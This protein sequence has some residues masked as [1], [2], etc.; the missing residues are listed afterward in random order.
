MLSNGVSSQLKRIARGSDGVDIRLYRLIV[1]VTVFGVGHHIDHVIRGNHVGWP[2]IPE[3]TAF[4]YSLGF[5]PLIALGL[6]LSLAD[7]VGAGYWAVVTGAGFVMV[8]VL[9][10]GPLAVEPPGDVVGPYESATVGYVA[11]A[12]LV[13]FV[14]TLA[15]T[16][17][18]ASYRWLERVRS[19]VQ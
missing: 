13:G 6:A 11:L 15:V 1:L 19:D 4:T 9:H 5:Y 7:R 18:Y 12:W 10:F 17:G 8:T 14:A 2:L 16:T 3:V